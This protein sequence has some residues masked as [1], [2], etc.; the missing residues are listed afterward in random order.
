[1]ILELRSHDCGYCPVLPISFLA[2]D[3]LLFRVAYL[4]LSGR[5]LPGISRFHVNYEQGTRFQPLATC[6]AVFK[7]VR[8][9]HTWQRGSTTLVL[10]YGAE[11]LR[12]LAPFD[13]R[14]EAA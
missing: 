12:P 8:L 3:R 14:N 10:V 9:A 7:F 13:S 4:V 1:M 5:R 6:A 2:L 11:Q